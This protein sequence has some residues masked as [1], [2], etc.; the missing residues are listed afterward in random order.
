MKTI[1]E[2]AP[3]VLWVSNLGGYWF[4]RERQNEFADAVH[5]TDTKEQMQE[6]VSENYPT[7]PVNWPT[8]L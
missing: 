5:T 3:V 4:L 7:T 8:N 1:D 2:N 6:F